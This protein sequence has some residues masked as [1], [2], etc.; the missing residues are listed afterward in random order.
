MKPQQRMQLIYR[1]AGLVANS[2]FDFSLLKPVNKSAEFEK[3]L[4]PL[5]DEED[6]GAYLDSLP[7]PEGFWH[8]LPRN[9]TAGLASLGH[10]TMNIPHDIAQSVEGASQYLNEN[11]PNTLGLKP[12]EKTFLKDFK[13][14]DYIPHQEE[15]NFAQMLGQ[16]GEG[17]LMDKLIQ[18]G[19]EYSP[20]LI[21]GGALLHGGARALKGTH[22]LDEVARAINEGGL[23]NFSYPPSV[24]EEARNYL[25]RSHATNE[26]IAA[27]EAGN[28]PSSFSMQSQIGK[29]QRDLAKSPLAS[30]RLLAPRAGELKQNM[31]SELG[32]ILRSQGMHSEADMLNQGINNYR[33]YMKVK[34][35][36]MP[37]FKKLGIPTTILAAIGFGYKKAQKLLSD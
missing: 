4:K 13:L 6:Q 19:V 29:H 10:S 33:Q 37:A 5:D 35:A 27:S 23:R 12:P 15:K 16:Q 30:E 32:N 8:K 1:R 36:V 3:N 20:E 2:K 22:Q 21:T 26:M 7:A 18:K 28:Y 14:S 31:L 24:V 11:F 34:N 17:T 9:I 25:P